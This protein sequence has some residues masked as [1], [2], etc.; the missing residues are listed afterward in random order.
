MI[1]AIVLY[2][3][4][5]YHVGNAIWEDYK[6]AHP[7]VAQQIKTSEETNPAVHSIQSPQDAD[8]PPL[9]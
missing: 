1:L 6:K 2:A 7:D 4:K 5:V 3:P 9:K 8:I